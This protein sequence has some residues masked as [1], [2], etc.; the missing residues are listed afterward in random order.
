MKIVKTATIVIA[1]LL[2]ISLISYFIPYE[3]ILARIPFFSSLYNNTSLTINSKNGKSI[4][5]INGTNYGETPLTITN[6]GVGDYDIEM[7]RV[8]NTKD[9]YSKKEVRVSLERGT[10]AIVDYEIAPKGLTSGYVLYYSKSFKTSK[11]AGYISLSSAPDVSKVYLDNEFYLST[12]LKA[13][14]LNAKNYQVKVTKEGY[15]DLTFPI[16]IRNGYNLNIQT[17]LF[18]L[19]TTLT[20]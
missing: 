15:E 11:N 17:S 1:L 12:P 20:K 8:S 13:Q 3:Q 10:E 6:L 5:K 19:P 18:P 9:F 16:I 7:E 4:I 2:I 14:E